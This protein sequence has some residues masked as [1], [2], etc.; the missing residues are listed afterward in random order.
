MK[1]APRYET[2]FIFVV[3]HA[4]YNAVGALIIDLITATELL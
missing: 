4:V 2:V 3:I 1:E